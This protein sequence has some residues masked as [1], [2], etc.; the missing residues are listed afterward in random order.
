VLR[1]VRQAAES[2]REGG[3]DEATADQARDDAASLELEMQQQQLETNS[4]PCHS[5][6]DLHREVRR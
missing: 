3:A 6:S 4:Q 2:S 1:Q 5:L